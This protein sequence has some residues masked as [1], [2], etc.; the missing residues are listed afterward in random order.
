MTNTKYKASTA[1]RFGS[2]VRSPELLGETVVFTQKRYDPS[3]HIAIRGT[4]AVYGIDPV[5][6]P[7]S[8]EDLRLMADAWRQF[9]AAICWSREFFLMT[10]ASTSTADAPLDYQYRNG[11]SALAESFSRIWPPPSGEM[12]TSAMAI[13]QEYEVYARPEPQNVRRVK[14]TIARRVI[15]QPNPIL[16]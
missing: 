5:E 13:E 10:S 4:G 1:T 15:G 11:Y 6:R 8:T 14:V 3:T 7:M 2:F 16:E 9:D 12:G